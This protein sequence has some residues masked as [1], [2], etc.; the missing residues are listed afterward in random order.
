MFNDFGSQN[1]RKHASI[2]N[3]S[4]CDDVAVAACLEKRDFA[5]RSMIYII[6]ATKLAHTDDPL[7]SLSPLEGAKYIG[8]CIKVASSRTVASVAPK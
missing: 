3:L 4:S 2:V 1:D 7:K 8:K 5:F 6:R